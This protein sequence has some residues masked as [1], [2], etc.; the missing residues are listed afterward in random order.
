MHILQVRVEENPE[1]TAEKSHGRL[2]KNER[3]INEMNV[4]FA[5]TAACELCNSTVFSFQ[6]LPC[7]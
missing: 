6:I 2:T 5:C 1:L 3:R 4:Y 7:E